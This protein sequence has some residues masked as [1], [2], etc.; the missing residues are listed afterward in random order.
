MLT[1]GKSQPMVSPCPAGFQLA[2]LRGG[3]AMKGRAVQPPVF[4]RPP[5]LADGPEM[6]PAS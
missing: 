2:C 5:S 3:R 4:S 1:T 6:T